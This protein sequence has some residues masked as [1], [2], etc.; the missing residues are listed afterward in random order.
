APALAALDQVSGAVRQ[1]RAALAKGQP[2]S[3]ITYRFHRQVD[4]AGRAVVAADMAALQADLAVIESL[5]ADPSAPSGGPSPAA[6]LGPAT[7]LE[8]EHLDRREWSPLTALDSVKALVTAVDV[9]LDDEAQPVMPMATI[10]VTEDM[11]T[12]MRL[13]RLGWRS[14]YHHEILARGLAPEDL[15]TMLQ[16][17]LRWSQGTL[18]VMLRENPLVQR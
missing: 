13:H 17:R 10:S 4:A 5:S 3:E 7:G 14:V 16:Q 11:A 6:V 18:Q 8:L 2:V 9:H 12:A 1:A 15:R